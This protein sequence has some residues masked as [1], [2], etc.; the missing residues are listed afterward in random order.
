MTTAAELLDVRVGQRFDRFRW[1][2]LDRNLVKIGELTPAADSRPTITGSIER[3][4]MRTLSNV[5]ID[6]TDLREINVLTHRLRPVLELDSG[7]RFPLGVYLFGDTDTNLLADGR[8]FKRMSLPDQGWILDQPMHRTVAMRKGQGVQDL[9]V[10]LAGEVGITNVRLDTMV[11]EVAEPV[12][13]PAGRTSRLEILRTLAQL[14]GCLAPYFD[15]DGVLTCRQAPDPDSAQPDLVFE[16]DQMFA[17]SYILTDDTWRAPNR[18]LVIG[19]GNDEPVVGFYDIPPSAPHSIPNR[20]YVVTE[21][22]DMP[23]IESADMARAAARAAYVSDSRTWQLVSFTTA[24]DPR[25]DLFGLFQIDSDLYL[26]T[27]FRFE[28]TSGGGHQH[29][30]SKLWRLG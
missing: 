3:P 28:L 6:A 10:Q 7:D 30:G 12:V 19:D 20:G 5:E 2:V 13:F 9:F 18:Y 4:I 16:L 26:E 23:G 15:A 8:E 21:T 11:V 17:D 24:L 22:I 14:Q 1:E 25:L 29:V 27:E